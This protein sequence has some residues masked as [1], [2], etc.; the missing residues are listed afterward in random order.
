MLG[1]VI[2]PCSGLVLLFLLLFPM[3]IGG[4][5]RWPVTVVI[6]AAVMIILIMTLP[7]LIL[8][9]AAVFWKDKPFAIVV[10][11]HSADGL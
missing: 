8:A 1:L 11:R 5:T 4:L 2:G 10:P 3:G 7:L 6:S 9:C